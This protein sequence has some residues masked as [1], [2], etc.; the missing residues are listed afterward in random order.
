MTRDPAKTPQNVRDVRA[1]DAAIS[2]DLIHDD[3]AELGEE[4]P[5]ASVIRKD[6]L[7]E[8]VGVRED[9]VSELTQLSPRGPRRI[10]IVGP[11][12]KHTREIAGGVREPDQA[13]ELVLR[14]RLRRE[15]IERG[16]FLFEQQPLQDRNVIGKRLP[17]GRSRRD[18]D[19]LSRPRQIDCLRLVRIEARDVLGFQEVSERAREWLGELA[20]AGRA[21]GKRLRV[22]QLMLTATSIVSAVAGVLER[23]EQGPKL[24]ERLDTL[25]RRTGLG[26]E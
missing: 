17:R 23:E 25:T 3:E 7:V 26:L 11:R 20:V 9:R 10:A 6:A 22:D 5:P 13:A 2:V 16:R 12:R 21:R 15:E 8:H 18:D 19:M 14:E 1:E 24:L 4:P